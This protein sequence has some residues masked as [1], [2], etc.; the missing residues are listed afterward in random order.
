MP[1][2]TFNHFQNSSGG[3]LLSQKS[4]AAQVM[5]SMFENAMSFLKLASSSRREAGVSTDTECSALH[6]LG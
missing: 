6:G 5:L 2:R 4:L 3:F 1:C